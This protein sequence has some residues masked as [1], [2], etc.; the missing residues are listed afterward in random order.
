MKFT[1]HPQA[2]IKF[3]EIRKLSAGFLVF[4]NLCSTFVSLFRTL[5]GLADILLEAF[6]L[7]FQRDESRQLIL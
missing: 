3:F 7:S 1:I 5:C 2:P 6:W 4:S